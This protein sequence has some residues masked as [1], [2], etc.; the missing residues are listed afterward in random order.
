MSDTTVFPMIFGLNGKTFQ[1]V[2]ENKK[3]WVNFTLTEMKKPLGLFKV[4]QEYCKR[5]HGIR[6]QSITK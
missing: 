3:D 2:Y 4:W 1:W 5:K 6:T